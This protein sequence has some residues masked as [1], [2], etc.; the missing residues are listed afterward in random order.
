MTED[1]AIVEA[2]EPKRLAPSLE[3]IRQLFAFSGN[4]C[5][6]PDCTHLLLNEH[7]TFIAEIAH[8]EG[9]KPKGERFNPNMTNEQ[10]RHPSNLVPLCLA[11][12]KETD[13][14]AVWTV[15]K[16]RKM[17]ADHE[18]RFRTPE[19]AILAG[20]KDWT[21]SDE[22][23]LPKNLNAMFKG[24]DSPLIT[25]EGMEEDRE[26]YLK[27]LHAYLLKYKNVPHETKA[28]LGSVVERMETLEQNGLTRYEIHSVHI[29]AE[30]FRQAHNIG[31]AKF[32]R[33][34]E[35]LERY[36]LGGV[37]DGFDEP[38]LSIRYVGSNPFWNE[39]L[40]FCRNT[41]QSFRTYYLDLDFNGLEA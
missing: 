10:R 35:A 31:R 27:D 23:I 22:L 25:Q 39:V 18:S 12:H 21:K 5:F 8:I 29:P 41:N 24:I 4:L 26:R 13:N 38:T 40:M 14:E 1:T 15:E 30:D 37:S 28:F 16:M 19:K 9:V 2:D 3:T 34:C 6:F 11:H 32:A 36:S 17:K 33:D 20:L 7:G